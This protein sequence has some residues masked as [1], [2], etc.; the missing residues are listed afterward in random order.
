MDLISKP[1]KR[2]FFGLIMRKIRKVYNVKIIAVIVVGVFLCNASVYSHPITK[3]FLRVPMDK[4][5]HDRIM[6]ELIKEKLQEFQRSLGLS[7]KLIRRDPSTNKPLMRAKDMRFGVFSDSPERT[8]N[9]IL[10]LKTIGGLDVVR[11]KSLSEVYQFYEGKKERVLYHYL[12]EQIMG[13]NKTIVI[14]ADMT[15]LTPEGVE[16]FSLQVVEDR[17]C[18]EWQ[19]LARN[20]FL[21]VLFIFSEIDYFKYTR[22][23]AGGVRIIEPTEMHDLN[24][25]SLEEIRSPE[26]RA[27][28]EDILRELKV[29]QSGKIKFVKD[30]SKKGDLQKAP[31]RVPRRSRMDM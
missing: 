11:G 24:Y 27:Q 19:E 23:T 7:I 8:I 25:K 26:Y 18:P 28:E 6:D 1:N 12:K 4:D 3:N 5:T 14:Q 21:V 22:G 15:N 2:L 10:E 17:I 29:K 9:K 13:N 16:D 20:R 30:K 31:R